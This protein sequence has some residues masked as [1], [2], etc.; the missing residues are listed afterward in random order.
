MYAILFCTHRCSSSII[1]TI[2]K[3]KGIHTH[4]SMNTL[5]ICTFCASTKESC[6]YERPLNLNPSCKRQTVE[7]S[8]KKTKEVE[9]THIRT[10]THMH[11]T[12]LL[13][14]DCY[15]CIGVFFI[16]II[17]YKIIPYFVPCFNSMGEHACSLS[18]V[19]YY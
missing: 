14:A 13:L 9:T 18:T 10:H 8:K 5:H 16:I 11:A 1:S 3:F 15:A 6:V 17:E 2:S 7:R 19:D 4:N 12:W